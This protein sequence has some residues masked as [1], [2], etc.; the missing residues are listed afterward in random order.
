MVGRSRLLWIVWLVAGLG[1]A[2]VAVGWLVR[3]FEANLAFFPTNGEDETPA[4]YGATFA[5]IT[6]TTSDGERLRVWHL[7]HENA[8]ARVVY[9]HGNGGNL[10][11]WSEILVPIARQGFEVVAFDY[12]GY[13]LST[14]SPSEQGLYRDAEAI[15]ALVNDQLR[16]DDIPTIYWG[17]SLGSTMAAYAASLRRPD[18]VIIEAGF[19]S[20]RAVVRTNPVLWALSWFS[21][22]EFPTARWLA[23][24]QAPV[25]VI[26][27]DRDS[28]IPY[29]LGRE[30]H[31]SLPGTTPFV[32]VKGGDHNDLEP[33]D[34][35]TY[36]AAIDQ[37]VSAISSSRRQ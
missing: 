29:Q 7:T 34:A 8:R 31:A 1:L 21:S 37:F 23:S 18:G 36:W 20:M 27:G 25:L 12:R 32:T 26:H 14:G 19:P 35:A 2:L 30:L 10:S 22:Y 33:A 15:V 5:P 16:R 6:A 3:S 24:S 4:S 13:G 17:R 28:V 11:I 9:F